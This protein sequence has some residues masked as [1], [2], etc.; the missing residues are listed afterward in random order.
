MLIISSSFK[1]WSVFKFVLLYMWLSK[2]S[3]IF[4]KLAL[5]FF[6]F[7]GNK[8]LILSCWPFDCCLQTDENHKLTWDYKFLGMKKLEWS[9]IQHKKCNL[10]EYYF[11]PK[12]SNPLHILFYFIQLLNW[13]L[14]VAR[15]RSSHLPSLELPPGHCVASANDGPFLYK[16]ILFL[17]LHSS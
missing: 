11:S 10:G 9:K 13:N 5:H 4:R 12:I 1:T 15:A 3:S 7:V 17:Y 14:N 16:W 2:F 8:I 6:I